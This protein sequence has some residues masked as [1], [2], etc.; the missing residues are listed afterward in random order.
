MET[1]N[2]T[3]ASNGTDISVGQEQKAKIDE[4]NIAI[5]AASLLA[6]KIGMAIFV[7]TLISMTSKEKYAFA[8]E[9]IKILQLP[10]TNEVL[11]KVMFSQAFVCPQGG[12]RPSM[13]HRL[14]DQGASLSEVSVQLVSVQGSC[15][16][17]HADRDPSLG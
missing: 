14:H 12:L 5:Q 7:V 8:D 3:D 2:F 17:D 6:Y 16:E 13:H 1:V 15:Q 11:G 10:P 9:K 4:N